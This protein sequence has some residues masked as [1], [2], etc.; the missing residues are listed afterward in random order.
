M[1]PHVMHLALAAMIHA[2]R[3]AGNAQFQGHLRQL[4]IE[5][6]RLLLAY[7]RP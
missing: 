4:G 3:G 2:H 6:G 7:R 5:G 1:T